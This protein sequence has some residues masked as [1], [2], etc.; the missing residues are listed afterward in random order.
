MAILLGKM[1]IWIDFHRENELN[2]KEPEDFD[3]E[4]SGWRWG[5][6]ERDEMKKHI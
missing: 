2:M 5:E 3:S 1:M 6:R 4:P